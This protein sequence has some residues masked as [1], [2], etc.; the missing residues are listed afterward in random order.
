MRPGAIART[1]H[2][3]R[4]WML[5]RS[6]GTSARLTS[7]AS[8]RTRTGWPTAR[9][10]VGHHSAPPS[11]RDLRQLPGRIAL[12]DRRVQHAPASSP[13]TARQVDAR[14]RLRQRPAARDRARV[15]QHEVIGQP[16][17]LV[18]RWLT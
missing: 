17:D 8:T 15:Q 13:G 14:Q 10:G 5:L 3:S 6:G 18:A 7:R 16:R 4:F 1:V 9:P 12:R 11:K 2:G